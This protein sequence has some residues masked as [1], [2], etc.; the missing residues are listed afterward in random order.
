MN[1][2]FT[3]YRVVRIEKAKIGSLVVDEVFYSKQEA[4]D[5]KDTFKNVNFIE[6]IKVEKIT[7]IKEVIA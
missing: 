7:K 4:L 1:N 6:S 5:F 3:Y 2:E